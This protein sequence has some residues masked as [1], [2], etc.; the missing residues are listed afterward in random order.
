MGDKVL[1]QEMKNEGRKGGKLD[2]QF[3]GPYVIAKDLGKGR[4]QLKDVCGVVLKKSYNTQRLKV[5]LNPNATSSS[6]NQFGPSSSLF[7]TPAST[8]TPGMYIAKICP[9]LL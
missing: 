3:R 1:A 8:V 5:W 7:S 9:S 2:V 6:D 4:F